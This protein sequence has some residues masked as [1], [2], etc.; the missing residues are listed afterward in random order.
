MSGWSFE[1]SDCNLR[2]CK[3]SDCGWNDSQRTND[4]FS[5]CK[6]VINYDWCSGEWSDGSWN[7]ERSDSGWSGGER[8]DGGWVVVRGVM[9]VGWW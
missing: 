8:S 2:G 3:R 4:N 9:V 1:E 6:K 5:A 7:G